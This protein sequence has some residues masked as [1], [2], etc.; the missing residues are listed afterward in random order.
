[1]TAL[2]IGDKAPDFAA[3]TQEGKTISLADYRHHN[4]VVLFFYP[5]DYTPVCTKEACAFRDAYQ[6]FLE[7]GAIV[8]GVSSDS[9]QRHRD[10]AKTHRLPFPLLSDPQQTVRKAFGV[11]STLWLFPGRV[12][13]V[14]DAEG[15]I[16]HI[17]NS[18]LQAGQ[19][20]TEALAIV[21]KLAKP[22]E[23]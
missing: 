10:F 8:L 23:T 2:R 22:P 20:V 3:Q 18:Q 5:Q 4:L 16:R 9:E 19:H 6:D 11:P 14:I 1:M 21:Q 12:T 13:Y 17:F 15:I 7:A